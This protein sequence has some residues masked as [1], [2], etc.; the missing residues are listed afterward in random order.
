MDGYRHVSYIIPYIQIVQDR[1]TPARMTQLQLVVAAGL[2]SLGGV[3]LGA[4][5]TPLTQVILERVRERR[6]S[7]R[8]RRLI[9]GELLHAQMI[10]R[11]I[12]QTG[13]WPPIEDIDSF[14]PTSAWREHQSSLVGYVDDELWDRLSMTYA[15]MGRERDRFTN[16]SRLPAATQVGAEV[17]RGFK[18]TSNDLGK[19]RRKLTKGGVG[20][21]LDEMH[22]EIKAKREA[23]GISEEEFETKL[24]EVSNRR[25]SP[26]R[27]YL[28]RVRQLFQSTRSRE[29]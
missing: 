7:K 24:A 14:L 12:W 29:E 3:L 25:G 4:L 18:A 22:D 20:G 23:L 2:F 15:M 9:A 5:L 21:W 11:T 16:A 27:G 6:A 13:T 26:V 10:L 8:A 19:L 28:Q 1:P 17:A